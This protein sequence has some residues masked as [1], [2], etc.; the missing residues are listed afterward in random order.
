[1][2]LQLPGELATLLQE[3]GYN[4]P[5]ADEEKLFDLANIWLEFAPQL[6]PVADRAQSAAQRVW[7]GNQ[8]DAIDAFRARFTAADSA[9][10]SLRD[11]VTG[12]QVVG[13]ALM[14]AAAVVLALKITVIV[15]LVILAI[16]IV[17]AI[18]TAVATFG[19]SLLEIPIFKIL[20]G[21]LIDLAIDMAIEAILG[22]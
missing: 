10:A 1:M 20:T 15:Q 3:L 22:A 13:P 5:E 19:A 11:G 6:V 16:Q 21:E 12:A 8:G 14:V 9:L 2:G 7:S 17:Q 4:W 18:A